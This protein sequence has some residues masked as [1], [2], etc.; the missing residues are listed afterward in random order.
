MGKNS[1]LSSVRVIVPMR[2]NFAKS[3]SRR[4]HTT[5]VSLA[6]MT[7]KRRRRRVTMVSV[8]AARF[9][10]KSD[11]GRTIDRAGLTAISQ[12]RGLVGVAC[13]V[14]TLGAVKATRVDARRDEEGKKDRR[15]E[16][17][18][19]DGEC[20]AEAEEPT[21]LCRLPARSPRVFLPRWP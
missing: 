14:V 6:T 4:N 10:D 7:W 18:E 2:I 11:D 1:K 12:G 8:G 17:R 16:G 9:R 21:S 13:P 5:Y 3:G 15:R 20:P 19:Q